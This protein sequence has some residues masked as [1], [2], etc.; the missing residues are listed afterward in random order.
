MIERVS[1][2]IESLCG[3]WTTDIIVDYNTEYCQTEYNILV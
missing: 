1:S 2:V 3:A